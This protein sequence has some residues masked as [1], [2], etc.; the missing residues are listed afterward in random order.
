MFLDRSLNIAL[1]ISTLFHAA[2]FLPLPQLRNT[3][4]K[5]NLPALKITYL[6]PEPK[7]TFPVKVINK[8]KPVTVVRHSDTSFKPG[9]K[10]QEKVPSDPQPAIQ[11]AKH[12]D[13]K[14]PIPPELPKEKEA[15]YLDYYQSIRE[16][17]RKFVLDNYPRYIAC[18]E[19]CLYFILTSD[20]KLREISVVEQRSSQNYL[21]KEIAKRSVLQASPFLAFP[22]GLTQAQLSFNVVISFELE[23]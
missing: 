23:N 21:L 20:G 14:I 18:G 11:E 6:P 4:I 7:E 17:I 19:V 2:I 8:S 10:P 22:E 15:L 12:Q 13:I 9:E 3:L 1:L 5:E 16:K